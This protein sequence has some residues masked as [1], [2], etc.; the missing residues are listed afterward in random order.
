[1]IDLD[2]SNMEGSIDELYLQLEQTWGEVKNIPIEEKYKQAENIVVV[3]MG[4]S[5]LGPHV[6]KSIYFDSL[7]VPLEIVNGYD[8][9]GYA[10]DKTLIVLSS[11]SGSTEEVLN[12]GLQAK[13]RNTMVMGMCTGGK[14]A[15]F[16]KEN[17]YP[18]YIFNQIHNPS[19]QPRMSTGYMILGMMGLFHQ[20]GF[21][22]VNDEEIQSTIAL[23]KNNLNV[24]KMAQE[25]AQK[26]VNNIIILVGSTFLSG[27]VH[28]LNNQLNENAKNFSSYFLIPELNHHLM[29][30]LGFPKT[31][32][33]NLAFLFFNSNFYSERI[34]ER[35]GLTK[36]VVEKNGIKIFEF[37]PTGKTKI[38]QSF[39]ILQFGSYM[40]FYLAILNGLNP[41]PIPWVDFFKERL[42]K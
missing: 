36:E 35:F 28:T 19:K 7:K 13:Q 27:T 42:G 32:R 20:A 9:P 11:N 34:Q 3:G 5:A 29:E 41:S 18:A 17:N 10:N 33:E 23:L 14:L 12:A 24:K 31:N 39:E 15:E 26:L 1:M 8:L 16:L 2:K 21:I 38:E 37:N 25:Y 4:G 22:K 40:G 30:G 6:V